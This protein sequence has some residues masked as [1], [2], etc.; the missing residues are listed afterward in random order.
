MSQHEQKGLGHFAA[1][2]A[3][4]NAI[5]SGRLS[6]NNKDL[7]YAG[8]YMYMGLGLDGEDAFK[9]IDTRQYL[10]SD[11]GVDELYQ[12]VPTIYR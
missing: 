11:T 10:Q 6:E 3:F 9:H 1:S 2:K 7:N 5:Q 12:Y 4:H 8:D